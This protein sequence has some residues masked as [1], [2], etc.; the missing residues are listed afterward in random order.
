MSNIPYADIYV[1]P[2][3]NSTTHGKITAE[4]NLRDI[5][6]RLKM[7]NFIV[8]GLAI[9]K[10]GS[11]LEI[12][13]GACNIRG[14]LITITDTV[15]ISNPTAGSNVWFKLTYDINNHLLAGVDPNDS[16]LIEGVEVVFTDPSIG[17]EG[18]YLQIGKLD[19][20]G[21]VDTDFVPN[22]FPISSEQIG[23]GVD[24]STSLA[25]YITNYINTVATS[26]Y[27]SKVADDVKTGNVKFENGSDP[28][29]LKTVTIDNDEVLFKDDTTKL[30]DIQGNNITS[31]DAVT[32]TATDG[33]TL[34]VNGVSVV[35]GND[36]KITI[37]DVVVDCS[38]AGK[39]AIS[40][41]KPIEITSSSVSI[42][43]NLSVSGDIIGARVFNAVYK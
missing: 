5:V 40:S 6:T 27:L 30:L 15:S 36:K 41:S 18:D 39:V 12:A 23:S 19:A 13:V 34:T 4:D 42:S 22:S 32:L 9:S 14:Y 28:T 37:G 16:T 38:N 24:N 11:N 8:E 26:T 10:N 3:S 20:N 29:D 25:Q 2:S 21:D 31:D 7:N 43:G 35:I 1:F 33:I 17:E